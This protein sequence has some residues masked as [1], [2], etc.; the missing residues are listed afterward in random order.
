VDNYAVNRNTRSR[1]LPGPVILGC[2]IAMHIVTVI[3]YSPDWPE[4]FQSLCSTL[5]AALG[6]TALAIEHVGSTAVPGLRAK[7][8]IDIDVVVNGAQDMNDAIDKLSVIGYRHCG[9]LGV[10]G[11][12]AF[13]SRHRSPR[14]N[15]YLCRRGSLGLRNHLAVRDAL[16]SD[17]ELAARYGELKTELANRFPDN[18]DLY[19]D[20]KT[21]FLVHI[22]E[23]CDF[24]AAEIES[25]R[26]SNQID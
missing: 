8:V 21:E 26:R 5:K 19:V 22:L 11:R 25:I 2:Y 23:Q 6:D 13:D 3:D 15:L 12:E 17:H 14:H 20:G 24:P 18:I 9:D 4:Q 16:R 7:A 1:Q 10:D